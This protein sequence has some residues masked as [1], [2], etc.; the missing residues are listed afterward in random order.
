MNTPND[1]NLYD[2]QAN[3]KQALA[4]KLKNTAVPGYQVAFDPSEAEQLGAFT[5]DA[6]SE[7]DA[8]DSTADMSNA[9]VSG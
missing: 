5:E 6:L 9:D 2:D 7:A 4:D 8:M 3:A 1:S